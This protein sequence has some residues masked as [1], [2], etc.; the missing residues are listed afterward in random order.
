LAIAAG[1]WT[2]HLLFSPSC[3]GGWFFFS[4]KSRLVAFGGWCFTQ[5]PIV[6]FM[7]L[8]QMPYEEW[9]HINNLEEKTMPHW[10]FS[11]FNEVIVYDKAV[12]GSRKCYIWIAFALVLDCIV[13]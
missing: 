8:T 12:C 7:W 2:F 4:P 11:L 9:I 10:L 1:L 6:N 3:S 13:R 5:S